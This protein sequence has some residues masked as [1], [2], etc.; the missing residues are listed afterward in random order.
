MSNNK[1]TLWVEKYRPTTIDEYIGDEDLKNN[2]KGWVESQDI[3]HLLLFGEPGG[4][5]TSLAKLLIKNIDCDYLYINASDDNGIDIIRNRI[6]KFAEIASFKPLKIVIL[7]E[8]DGLSPEAQKALNNIIESFSIHTRFILTCNNIGM[9][10]GPL[11]SRC[12]C[13]HIIALDKDEIKNIVQKIADNEG[14]KYSTTDIETLISKYYPDIR[15]IIKYL[16]AFSKDKTL[17]LSKGITNFEKINDEI[18]SEIIS[19]KNTKETFSNIRNI[20]ANNNVKSFNE[21]YAFLFKN[22]NLISNK[23]V[24]ITL[25]ISEYSYRN[26]FPNNDKEINFMACI[27]QI[28]KNK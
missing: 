8:A 7:D 12:E 16:Q 10:I 11:I 6:K 27:V 5:K 3:P 26:S 14:I 25:S 21:I 23:L 9:V 28:L 18:L 2:I 22:I 19:S 13:H 17:D 15:S 4:G 20:I 1:H 24:E